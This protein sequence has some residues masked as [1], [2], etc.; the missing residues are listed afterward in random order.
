MSYGELIMTDYKDILDSKEQFKG[1]VIIDDPLRRKLVTFELNKTYTNA[2]FDLGEDDFKVYRRSP[3]NAVFNAET[4]IDRHANIIKCFEV[5][6]NLS[7]V[8]F[9]DKKN[10]CI[11]SKITIKKE[12][13]IE[14]LLREQISDV[15]SDKD[16]N[17]IIS[18]D[19]KNISN[20]FS[21]SISTNEKHAKMVF[22]GRETSVTANGDYSRLMSIGD[23]TKISF[24]GG[25]SD[26]IT[27]GR[28]NW[29]ASNGFGSNIIAMGYKPRITINA[30]A[31]KCA[32]Y[33]PHGTLGILGR[34]GIFKG[35][36]GTIVTVA[37]FSEDGFVRKFV[38][39]EIGTNGLI[40]NTWYQVKDGE[41]V[42]ATSL[43]R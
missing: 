5:E 33:G 17:I 27:T 8:T 1:Y 41:F 39:G 23:R 4:L 43:L 30:D 7:D 42:S 15:L 25:Y 13:T 9:Y 2:D 29:V 35:P 34:H 11:V 31:N 37:D 38:S 6:A 36:K 12:L 22:L 28:F 40:P 18:N 24:N 20:N 10:I 14:E 26:V 32:I 3:F 21:N 16:P 19:F